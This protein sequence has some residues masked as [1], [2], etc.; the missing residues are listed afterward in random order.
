[1]FGVGRF[2]EGQVDEAARQVRFGIGGIEG[3]GDGGIRQRADEIPGF[4]FGQAAQ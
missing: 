1:M 3:N 4:E 2:V